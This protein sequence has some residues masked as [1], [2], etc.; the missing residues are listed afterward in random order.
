[1]LSGLPLRS[2]LALL[3]WASVSAPLPLCTPL[4]PRQGLWRL[5]RPRTGPD[6]YP[7]MLWESADPPCRFRVSSEGEFVACF[8]NRRI[9]V[10][11]DSTGRNLLMCLANFLGKCGSTVGQSLGPADA[12]TLRMCADVFGALRAHGDV[13]IVTPPALGN[14]TLDFKWAPFLADVTR[15][16]SSLLRAPPGRGGSDA[17][18]IT[19]GYW[20]AKEAR[21]VG[22]ESASVVAFV[23]ELPRLAAL[24]RDELARDNPAVQSGH[25]VYAFCPYSEELPD[26]GD[27][28]PAIVDALNAAAGAALGS[29]GAGLAIF[30]AS[31]Y[32]RAR[33]EDVAAAGGKLV[34]W[35]LYHPGHVVV[36][37][38]MR[39]LLSHFC[40]LPT[41][42]AAAT[43]AAESCGG[44]QRSGGSSL[45]EG[46]LAVEPNAAT[47]VFGPAAV[48]SDAAVAALALFALLSLWRCQ[49]GRGRAQLPVAATALTSWLY[50]VSR[51]CG[52]G[53]RK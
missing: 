18:I 47:S 52:P 34:T 42:D 22:V 43:A 5:D 7:H 25:V 16:V 2:S 24:I 35:D 31:W 51:S 48:M 49:C 15:V 41:W 29:R 10:V 14:V 44:Q 50:A 12:G 4:A 6:D 26:G 30:N 19:L 40:G 53:G 11:G 17:T 13:S 3:T 23:D 38:L 39:D 36:L 28:P 9:S 32:T 1:M 46:H 37:T 20:T 27:F 33:P 8:R 45:M 21:S